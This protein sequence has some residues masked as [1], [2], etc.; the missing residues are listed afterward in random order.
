VLSRGAL[1]RGVLALDEAV[2]LVLGALSWAVLVFGAVVWA[3]FGALS[4]GVLALDVAGDVA[5]VVV[6][7][8]GSVDG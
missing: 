3:V 6:F 7:A 2:W 8:R 1:A 4:L 5:C